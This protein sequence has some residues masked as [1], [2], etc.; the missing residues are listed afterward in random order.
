MGWLGRRVAWP[1]SRRV[2]GGAGVGEVA[3]VD[4]HDAE[5]AVPSGHLGVVATV[6]GG[7][8]VQLPSW[9]WLCDSEGPGREPG[10]CCWPPRGSQTGGMLLLSPEG[11]TVSNSA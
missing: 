8:D 10:P 2:R 6:G 9:L 7:V 11:T 3:E 1:I 4:E 5:V